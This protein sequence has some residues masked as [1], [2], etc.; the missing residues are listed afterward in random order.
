MVMIGLVLGVSL[1]A[2]LLLYLTFGANRPDRE[3]GRGGIGRA[4]IVAHSVVYWLLVAVW[5][6]IVR[7]GDCALED[8]AG[9]CLDWQNRVLL[10][11]A[12]IA[13]AVYAVGLWA[14]TRKRR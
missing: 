1:A 7:M 14:L 6:L 13:A 4:W 12:G 5:L 11:S 9:A 3:G 10:M 8:D 2:Y